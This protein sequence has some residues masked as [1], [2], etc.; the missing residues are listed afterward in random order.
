[1]FGVFRFEEAGVIGAVVIV[2]FEVCG[3]SIDGHMP[4]DALEDCAD[5]V[6]VVMS[7]DDTEGKAFEEFI[8][9]G[10]GLVELLKFFFHLVCS[11][12]HR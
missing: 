9:A 4:A 2:E 5:T 3:G 10:I 8:D 7:F 12:F 6:V 1:M 11:A